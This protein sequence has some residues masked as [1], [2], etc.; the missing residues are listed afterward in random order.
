MAASSATVLTK[1][2]GDELVRLIKANASTTF[3]LVQFASS[4]VFG[5]GITAFPALFVI[6]IQTQVTPGFVT[7][8]DYEFREEFRILYVFEHGDS[9]S[10]IV[11]TMFTDTQDI[12]AALATD[13]TLS[14]LYAT[15]TPDIVVQSSPELYEWAPEEDQTLTEELGHPVKAVAIQWVVTWRSGR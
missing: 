5:K 4:Q 2:I 10:A 14:T 12:V 3:G 1:T 11:T 7:Q 13:A 6:P 9:D 15:T 8:A